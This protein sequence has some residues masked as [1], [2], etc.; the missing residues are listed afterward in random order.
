[1][2]TV[3]PRPGSVVTT[4]RSFELSADTQILVQHQCPEVARIG[5]LPC[6][7]PAA[8]HGFSAAGDGRPRAGAG[9][10]PSHH[11][12]RRPGPGHRGLRAGRHA[13]GRFCWRPPTRLAC[14]TACRRSANCCR[15]PS[16]ARHRS[17][18]RG[19]CPPASSATCRASPGAAPCS[20]WRATS[21]RWKTSSATSISS[22]ATSSTACTCTSATTRAGASRSNPGPGW[23]PTA[24]APP[25]AAT[26]A[27]TTRRS[28]TPTSS[29]TPQSATSP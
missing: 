7:R 4:G 17:R 11:G 13:A 26:P 3:I 5:A 12:G 29:A 19:R 27:A 6:R 16:N 15:P 25:W 23:P 28:N 22:P 14:S 2:N 18:D 1:M 8:R 20:T 21:S 10:H 9:R 24:G